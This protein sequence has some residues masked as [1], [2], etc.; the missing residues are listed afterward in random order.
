MFILQCYMMIILTTFITVNLSIP[1]KLN[2]PQ[3]Y[4][5]AIA[6]TMYYGGVIL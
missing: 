4:A 5:T 1:L 6:T 2:Y 3:C